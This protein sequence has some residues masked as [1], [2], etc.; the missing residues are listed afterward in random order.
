M[1][2][3]DIIY[4]TLR[5]DFNNPQTQEEIE[6][7]RNFIYPFDESWGNNFIAYEKPDSILISKNI[8]YWVEHFYVDG[9]SINRK[10]SQYKSYTN[11]KLF[12]IR[13]DKLHQAWEKMTSKSIPLTYTNFFNNFKN[14]FYN[15]FQ[16]I[17]SYK[18]NIKKTHSDKV[19]KIIF[20]VELWFMYC[21][22]KNSNIFI[23]KDLQFIKYLH[24]FIWSDL[25]WIILSYRNIWWEIIFN[26]FI[27][28]SES[29]SK[30]N[31]DWFFD[32]NINEIECMD[33]INVVTLSTPI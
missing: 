29:L 20:L 28:I 4:Y 19:I 5:W 11:D 21:K 9:S 18:Q 31:G 30:Y 10:G 17:N 24:D 26:Q 8:V 12:K 33:D 1:T 14:T 16:K 22:N 23:W 25:Y 27:S 6:I 7:L 32:S 2:D 13:W 15:H 3:S